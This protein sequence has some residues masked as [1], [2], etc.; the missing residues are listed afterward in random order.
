MERPV[1]VQIVEFSCSAVSL[2]LC[3]SLAIVKL[4]T[5]SSAI[6]FASN[7]FY[8]SWRKRRAEVRSCQSH[9]A[10]CGQ[11]GGPQFSVFGAL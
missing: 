9:S 2:S 8:K 7:L 4:G 5:D 1:A 6:R 3:L 10:T 11:L